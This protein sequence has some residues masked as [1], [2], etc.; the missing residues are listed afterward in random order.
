MREGYFNF[1]LVIMSSLRTKNHCFNWLVIVVVSVDIL[2]VAVAVVV[3]V[4]V[5]VVVIVVV[6]SPWTKFFIRPYK[7]YV[8]KQKI[9]LRLNPSEG[10]TGEST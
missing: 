1:F 8:G 5:V 4:V 3:V 6:S 2:F 7:N 9:C 10:V